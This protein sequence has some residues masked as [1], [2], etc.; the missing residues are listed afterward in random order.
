M[1]Q[2]PE[3]A[4]STPQTRSANPSSAPAP[5]VNRSRTTSTGM[6]PAS[7]PQTARSEEERGPYRIGQD[8]QPASDPLADARARYNAAQAGRNAEERNRPPTGRK[9]FARVPEGSKIAL[10]NAL[11]ARP[12]NEEAPADA[13][14]QEEQPAGEQPAGST[15][16]EGASD[17]KNVRETLHR[18]G[19]YSYDRIDSMDVD[20]ARQL[21]RKAQ[22]QQSRSAATFQRAQRAEAEL[23][24]LRAKLKDGQVTANGSANAPQSRAPALAIDP[25]ALAQP[26]ASADDAQAA[27]VKQLATVVADLQRQVQTRSVAA[28][29]D[30]ASDSQDAPDDLTIA[31]ELRT[32]F[33]ESYPDL[34]EDDEFEDIAA[35]IDRFSNLR[36][37]QPTQ[38]ETRRDYIA[39]LMEAAIRAADLP[40]VGGRSDPQRPLRRS[41]SPLVPRNNQRPTKS[42]GN[43]VEDARADYHRRQQA[44]AGAPRAVAGF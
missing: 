39:R 4:D 3:N 30:T 2:Q 35:T 10:A 34:S 25:D 7:A 20:E 16:D 19:L 8:R 36:Q 6:P 15:R 31:S 11:R 21:A 42:T 24:Q 27:T 29:A 33:A 28:Q 40:Q 43:P 22:R 1:T 38:G 41:G 23:A 14:A 44:R 37:Y 12:L 32:E 26:F 18:T 9:P 13:P 17:W 5:R